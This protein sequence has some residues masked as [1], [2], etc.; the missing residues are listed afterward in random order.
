MRSV[1]E[2]HNRP[3]HLHMIARGFNFK[4]NETTE[5]FVDKEGEY[6]SYPAGYIRGPHRTSEGNPRKWCCSVM[7]FNGSWSQRTFKSRTDTHDWAVCFAHNMITQEYQNEHGKLCVQVI[8]QTD[9]PAYPIRARYC[10]VASKREETLVWE[11]FDT[12]DQWFIERGLN[13]PDYEG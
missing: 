3:L 1:I 2:E 4:R 10:Y 13:P 12:E 9:D 6:A 11:E 5:H 7:L 8:G